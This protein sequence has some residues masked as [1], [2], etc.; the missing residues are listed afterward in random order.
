[1][2]VPIFATITYTVVFLVVVF[3]KPQTQ[4]RLAFRWYLFAM[5]IWSLSSFFIFV[6]VGEVVFWFRMMIFA[7][8]GSMVAI[9]QFVQTI[10]ARQRKWA[11]W[12]YWYGAVSMLTGL[13][14]NLVIKSASVQ[15][16][17]LSY[18]FSP[19][20]ILIAGPGYGLTL[21]SFRE[22]Y[23]GYQES[24]DSYQRNRLRYLIL[25]LYLLL[26]Y[27]NYTSS[28]LLLQETRVSVLS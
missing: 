18:E 19:F 8:I 3:S 12:V 20:T 27:Y 11:S 5:L 7:A 21:F 9:F 10:L 2:L 14:T 4:A 17:V 26:T 22:L 13:L 24:A 6:D 1:M 25:S 16:G 15:G 23:R 28:G